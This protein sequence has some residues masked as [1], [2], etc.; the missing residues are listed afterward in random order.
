MAS[1]FV[2]DPLKGEITDKRNVHESR[3]RDWD[4]MVL[5]NKRRT[6]IYH[7]VESGGDVEMAIVLQSL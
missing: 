4:W 7:C 6:Y 3:D 1:R 5:L 2:E